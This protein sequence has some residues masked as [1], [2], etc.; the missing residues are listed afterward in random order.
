MGRARGSA[1][2]QLALIAAVQVLV[3]ATWF[4]ASAVVPA[5]RG[6]WGITQG[7]ATWLTVS[8]QLGFVTGAVLAAVL[9]LPD[10]IPAHRLV[11][12]C[13]LAASATTASVAAFAD[14][15]GTAVPLRFAT[16][17]ALAGVYPPGLK[18]MASWFER[19]RGF[20]LGLLVGALTLGSSLPQLINGFAAL[21]WRTVLYV[22]CALAAAGALLA[23]WSVRPGPHS[24]AA[25]PFAPRYMVTL[26]RERGPLLANLG[27]LGHMWELYAVWTWLPA[28][29][30]ASQAAHPGRT[31]GALPPGVTAFV[32]I[33]VAGLAGCL[34]AGWLG[35]RVGRARL[36][37]LAMTVSGTCCLLAAVVFGGH[38]LLVF[39]V[40]IVWGASVIADSG[41]FSACTSEVADRRYVG[42]A[43][44]T[45]TAAGFLLTVVTI[46]AT[47]LLAEAAG[48]R[49]AVAVLG[50]GPL[51]G[52]VA[53]V[54]LQRYMTSVHSQT[55]GRTT[56]HTHEHDMAERRPETR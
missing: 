42:T 24:A 31:A 26:F 55:T 36:A 30:T 22:S 2:A 53:M 54:L 17:V 23:A 13:A 10:V 32:A 20:A 34:L 3:M 9:N 27:Y 49:V 5:L 56:V 1:R 50:I 12:V 7:A 41:L 40:L 28:Y 15:L 43:L 6:E 47:P 16:G 37:A 19:G 45:Q 14:G 18:L 51:A 48:W 8:V 33:G 25:A 21:P 29:I 35:D 52:A 44:T 46:Q 38:P 4:S 39:A 11:A